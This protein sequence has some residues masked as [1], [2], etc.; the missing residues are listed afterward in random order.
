MYRV[1]ALV[2]ISSIS[3]AG[4]SCSGTA[5]MARTTTAPEKADEGTYP[6]WYGSQAVVSNDSIMIAYGAAI[7]DDSTTAV[8]KSIRSAETQLQSAVSDELEQVRSEA[9]QQYDND[10]GLNTSGF[11]IALRKVD[12]TLGELTVTGKTEVRQVENFESHRGFAEIRISKDELRAHIAQ[13][14]QEYDRAWKAMR[15]SKAFQNF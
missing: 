6:S 4:I 2:I 7:G 14:L 3:I 13:Q 9:I 5:E 10:Y 11:L 1:L 8:S 12:D 15:D